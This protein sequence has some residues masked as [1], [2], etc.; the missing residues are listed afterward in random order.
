MI[1]IG[2]GEDEDEGGSDDSREIVEYRTPEPRRARTRRSDSDWL[3]RLV[4]AKSTRLVTR[5]SMLVCAGLVSLNLWFAQDK[6]D[7]FKDEFRDL[8]DEQKAIGEKI[9]GI[10]KALNQKV[11]GIDDALNDKL[12]DVI[13]NQAA[14][15]ADRNAQAGQ[16]A[17]LKQQLDRQVDALGNRISRMGDKMFEMLQSR[18]D[19]PS[20]N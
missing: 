8:H 11:D 12:G 13:A 7:Q 5:A 9:D 17:D 15:L 20:G 18:G 3:E 10:D 6:Y 14:G 4:E 1:T 2:G 19:R 16:I